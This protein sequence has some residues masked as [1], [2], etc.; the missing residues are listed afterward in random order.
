[1]NVVLTRIYLSDNSH[2]SPTLLA[3]TSLCRVS[4]L[5]AIDFSSIS[6][7]D[8]SVEFALSKLR[9]NQRHGPL[10]TF[11]IARLVLKSRACPLGS[12]K[13]FAVRSEIPSQLDRG[14]HSSSLD[15]RCLSSGIETSLFS[16]Y[17]TRGAA[18]SKAFAGGVPVDR[19]LKV[20]GWA[21]ESTF[22]RHN[23]RPAEGLDPDGEHKWVLSFVLNSPRVGDALTHSGSEFQVLAAA[24]EK[25]RSP[26]RA[27][28]ERGMSNI[29]AATEQ[30][31]RPSRPGVALN[32]PG[33]L[34]IVIEKQWWKA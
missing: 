22:S 21:T 34:H 3:L 9:K 24:T 7:S 12:R 8:S 31:R 5:A 33:Q 29:G 1:M 10:K 13:D 4:E 6:V 20:G 28:R 17:S 11:V 30:F 15:E 19:I 23:L 27:L 16:A 14:I 25:A 32:M 2:S 26:Q 18:A